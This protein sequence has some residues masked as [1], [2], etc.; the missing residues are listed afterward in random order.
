[1]NINCNFAQD[2]IP[3]IKALASIKPGDTREWHWDAVLK[4][5]VFGC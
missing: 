5:F 1:M 4:G 3:I 2:L